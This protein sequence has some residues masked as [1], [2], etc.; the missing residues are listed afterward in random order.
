MSIRF[1]GRPSADG[2]SFNMIETETLFDA[3]ELWAGAPH[4][5]RSGL[6]R[7]RKTP[8]Q[9]LQQLDEDDRRALVIHAKILKLFG[10]YPQSPCTV[11]RPVRQ[12]GRS[13]R[14]ARRTIVGSKKDDLGR[15]RRLILMSRQNLKVS[16]HTRRQS[17]TEGDE[18]RRVQARIRHA[19]K[20]EITPSQAAQRYPVLNQLPEP[21]PT[22]AARRSLAYRDPRSR[23]SPRHG[24]PLERS[25]GSKADSP[26]S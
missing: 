16:G 7:L 21:D 20:E 1:G 11:S 2:V 3:I 14:F 15:R 5:R 12:I 24:T 8:T 17:P 9:P 6:A 13:L 4:A 18:K 26:S 25:G 23:S 19:A 22:V 10:D